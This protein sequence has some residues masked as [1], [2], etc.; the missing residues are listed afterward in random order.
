MPKT[1]N[2]HPIQDVRI[3][4]NVPITTRD[5][6]KLYADVYRPD[7][8]RPYPAIVNRTPYLKDGYGHLAGY[9]HAHHLADRGYN[10]VIQ[11]VRG[12]G[13]S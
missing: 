12:T 13:H 5:G 8:D 1:M 6:V 7:D 11:D 3:M 10:V 9:A 2:G 4:Y